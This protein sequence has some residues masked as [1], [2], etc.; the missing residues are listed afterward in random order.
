MK[1]GIVI[2][3][4]ALVVIAGAVYLSRSY[5]AAWFAPG[6][7]APAASTGGDHSSRAATV[8]A[9]GERKILYWVDPMHPAYRSDKPGIAPDC[10]MQLVPVYADEAE[11]MK[12]MPP[13][14]VMITPAKQQLIGV[15]TAPVERQHLRRTI[16]AVGRV[17]F[18]ETKVAQIHTKVTGYVEDVFV[19][20]VGKS[21]RKGDPLFTVYSPDL[22]STQQEYL[23]ALRGKKYLSD[24]PFPEI[25]NS[26]DTLLRAARERL[27]L[28]DV[29][30]DQIQALEQE[31]KVQRTLTMYSPAT[32]IVTERAVFQKGR[33]ITPEISLYT[34]VDLS[35]A[36]VLAEIYEYEVP[37]VQV[38]QIA[39]MRLS[40]SLGKIFTGKITYI[41]PTL[42]PKT[43]TVKVRL[44]F[45]NPD[46]E[47]KPEMFTE[48][49]LKIDYGSQIV[50][51]QEAVLDAGTEQVVFV[52]HGGGY[53]EPRKIQIGAK[54]DDRIIVIGGLRP[55]ETI[56]TSGNFLI[57]SESRLKTAMGGMKH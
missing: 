50:V 12:D 5:I 51:P 43:R 24:A 19:D 48:V 2:S 32:G 56:V 10:G 14:S 11:A 34:I 38:G 54:V 22:V 37:D 27:L 45:P 39:T 57:D 53:F 40:Y 33:Y 20:F 41:Y 36:W 8:T 29:S 31:G 25:S 46:F 44:E 35:T 26:A 47:L 49:E 17:S 9:S 1:K 16:R 55:G 21:V 23:I 18:D 52:A 4:A 3:V 30:S 28:W 42:D 15:R 7:S 13:G 6:R